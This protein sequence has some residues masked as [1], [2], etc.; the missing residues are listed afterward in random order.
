MYYLSRIFAHTGLLIVIPRKHSGCPP[1]SKLLI[2]GLPLCI[3][4]QINHVKIAELM[5]LSCRQ[6]L[7]NLI[8]NFFRRLVFG[9]DN[10]FSQVV[11]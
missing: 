2:K 6:F 10:Q 8:T 9:I 11:I 3:A 4:Q 7:Q 5:L 1:H